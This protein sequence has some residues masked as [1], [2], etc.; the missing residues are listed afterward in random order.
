[1]N[2]TEQIQTFLIFIVVGIII[3]LI[4]DIFRIL[5]KVYK[6]SDM[7]IYMQ[8]ILFWLLTGIIILQSI[9]IFNS[10]DIRVFLF[11]GIFIGVFVYTS[12]FSQYI[13][14][15]G[16]IILN[17]FNKIINL[18]YTQICKIIR[19]MI[20]YYRNLKLHVFKKLKNT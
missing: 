19:F 3:S 18:I 9:F 7:L 8:D 16:T 20:K 4:F 2:Y 17:V 6:F 14:K 10:G 13:I 5:R 15:I 11:F 1:M 12:L